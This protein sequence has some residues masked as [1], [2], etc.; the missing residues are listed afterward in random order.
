[1]P[2]GPELHL[3][4][5]YVNKVAKGKTFK[6][7]IIKSEVNKNPNV[8]FFN[9]DSFTLKAVSRGK[10][11]KLMLNDDEKCILFR[12]GMSGSFQM[13]SVDDLH[14][15]SHLRFYTKDGLEVLSF[16]DPRR[17]GRWIINGDWGQDRGPDIIDEFDAFKQKIK[18]DLDSSALFERPICEVMM[19]Q[20]YF[21]GIGNY[22]RAEI[23]HKLSIR[24]FDKAK[25]VINDELLETCKKV[26]EEVVDLEV[27]YENKDKFTDWLQC[28]SKKGMDN[29]V[30]FQGRTIWFSFDV[31]A[32]EM[33]PKRAKKRKN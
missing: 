9:D 24:P 10:E 7:P 2:E 13:T 20:T 17:F 33:K 1:M 28:Y 31:G 18:S 5:F 19:N 8:D 3:S 4:A 6:G 25:N 21:N 14:K 12:F 23:L 32:G 26:M 16:V 11:L 15:H 29:L 30:D 27:H 22:L